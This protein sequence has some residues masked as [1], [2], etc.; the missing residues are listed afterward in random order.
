MSAEDLY[1]GAIGIGMSST[2]QKEGISKLMGQ[3]L[4]QPTPVS[5][6]GPTTELRLVYHVIQ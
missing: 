6:F 3:I 2:I 1:E 5:V 4:E